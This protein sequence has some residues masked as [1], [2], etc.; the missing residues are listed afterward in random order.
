MHIIL[1]NW[2]RGHGGAPARVHELRLDARAQG[3]NANNQI[4]LVALDAR[5]MPP[6]ALSA[7][8]VWV[9]RLRN[10]QPVRKAIMICRQPPVD[11]V[12]RAIRAGINDIFERPLTGWQIYQ[13]LARHQNDKAAH[14][15][16][17]SIL[18]CGHIFAAT[19]VSDES[20]DALERERRLEGKLK[21]V[22]AESARLEQLRETLHI[23]ETELIAR[24]RRVDEEFARLQGDADVKKAKAGVGAAPAPEDGAIPPGHTPEHERLRRAEVQL[25]ARAA[26]LD[27]RETAL[28]TRDR[29]LREFEAMLLSQSPGAAP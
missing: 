3:D 23:R 9:A 24:A 15:A 8:I 6:D 4:D 25:K 10:T 28:A 20:A 13:L 11:F 7:A 26:E 2:V 5:G 29:M 21:Q 1:L 17:R 18:Q 14:R 27:R 22:Q 19:D 16:A 12:V